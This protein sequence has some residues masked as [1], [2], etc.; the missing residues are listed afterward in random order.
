MF[1]FVRAASD[2][3]IPG[4]FRWSGLP[5]R[6]RMKDWLSVDEIIYDG[7]YD[8]VSDIIKGNGSPLIVDL[9]ANIGLFSVN[10]LRLAPKAKVHSFEASGD[11]FGILK[12]N[13]ELNPS[14]D[15]TVY[16]YALWKEDG[17]VEF[18]NSEASTNSRIGSSIGQPE[19]VPSLSLESLMEKILGGKRVRLMK[20][21]IEGAETG[22]I[23]GKENLLSQVDNIVIELHPNLH[24]MDSVISALGA[25]YPNLYEIPG[26]RS[27]K[28]LLLAS[29][30][31][32]ALPAFQANPIR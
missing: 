7:E 22:F 31:V 3:Q 18:G 6:S 28:P 5:F 24:P 4:D 12:A 23:A 15:W 17:F 26:R 29:R 32:F 20:I 30:E 8:F 2:S 21:D 10:A 13:Q 25:V 9:G 27:L 16:R 1:F 14:L 11:T 19:R